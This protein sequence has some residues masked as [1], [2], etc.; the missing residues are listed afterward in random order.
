MKAPKPERDHGGRPP[1]HGVHTLKRAVKALG[2]RAIDRRTRVGRALAEWRGNLVHDLGGEDALSTQKQA[3]VDEAV[4]AKLIVDSIDAWILEQP[5]LV[6]RRKRALLPVVRERQALVNTL[7]QLLLD[8]GL[9]RRT[10][11]LSVAD[12]MKEKQA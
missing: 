2:S 1:M 6:D 12:Y 3:L 8:L 9:E 5:A 4:K 10:R 11:E 7:R